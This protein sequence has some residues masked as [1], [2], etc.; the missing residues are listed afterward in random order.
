MATSPTYCLIVPAF[1]VYRYLV[2]GLWQQSHPFRTFYSVFLLALWASGW[3]LSLV[4]HL[5]VNRAT[6]LL[7][8]SASMRAYQ[9]T[10]L[11][12]LG[13]FIAYLRAVPFTVPRWV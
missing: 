3:S 12:L 2:R 6:P 8:C 4:F 7:S 1:P 10:G 5:S 13:Y 9:T 11:L